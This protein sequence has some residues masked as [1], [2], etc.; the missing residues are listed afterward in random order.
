MIVGLIL[1]S[2]NLLNIGI[3]LFSLTLLFQLLTLPVE[4]NASGR[5]LRILEG[6]NMLYEEEVRGARKVLR[7]AALTYVTAAVSTLLQ[8]L[9]LVLLFGRRNND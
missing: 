5:A 8:L 7:A 4:F 6:S 1:G 3:I 2:F 9:R